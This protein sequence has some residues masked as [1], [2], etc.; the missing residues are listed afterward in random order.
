MRKA[1]CRTQSDF[2]LLVVP[3]VDLIDRCVVRVEQG[4]QN[5]KTVYSDDPVGVIRNFAKN[6]GSLVHVVDLNAAIRDDPE[7][8]KETI[9]EILSK[10]GSIGVQLAGGIRSARRARQLLDEGARRVVISSIA[11]SKP[12]EAYEILQTF[13]SGRIVLALDYDSSGMVR[14]AGWL[15]QQQEG[16]SE[17]I[18]RFSKMGFDYFLTT[19]V[20]RDGLLQGP[21]IATLQKLRKENQNSAKIIASGGISSEADITQLSKIGIDE[22]IVG[23]AIYEGKI[24]LSILSKRP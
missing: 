18:S 9:G 7:T 15:K 16:V 17:A 2:E 10:S 19:A 12:D 14:T 6:G 13:G 20:E 5:R 11:Y 22:A 1:C 3:A 8:N 23:K 24:S 21:D 4:D